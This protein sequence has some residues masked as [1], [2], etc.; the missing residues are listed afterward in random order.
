MKYS[1]LLLILLIVC[2]SSYAQDSSAIQYPQE[3]HLKNVHQ[4][5]FGGD[6]AEAYWN[7]S[8]TALTYQY[9]NRKDDIYCDRIYYYPLSRF[10][11]TQD[12]IL[13]PIPVS[14]GKG[15]T[16]C[17][18]FLPGDS[19]ILYAS[20]LA[21]IDTCPQEPP[22]IKGKYLW[23][24]YP[25]Y[26]IYVSDLK[27]NIVKQLTDNSFYDAEATVSP[28]GDKIVF[29]SDRSGDVELYTMNIDGSGLKQITSELGYD[30][31]ACFSPDGKQIV[32]RSTKFDSEQEKADYK[33]L[34]KKHLVSPNKMELYIANADGSNRRKLTDL[35]G[36]NWAPFFSIDGQKVI[37]SSNHATKSI[38]FNLYM[39]D[40]N[41][42]NLEQIT[43]DK[44]FDSF[45][46]FTPDGKK[47]A[48]CSNRNNGGTRDTNI[49][50]A[51]WVP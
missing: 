24:L 16:T 41:G 15:R 39:I 47:I 48:W 20:T 10:Y 12:T 1:F 2:L 21:K 25:E 35:G 6:N 11:G 5:T 30:G 19:L 32:W 33:D 51:D 28:K 29:T 18:Y 46:M 44:V 31:G 4:L 42:K 36:A 3:R 17:S 43:Y 14:S 40:T 26:E 45:P 50:I 7:F 8:G 13:M 38:P 49:F 34:L 37:F 9:T 27:G 23:P 22:H